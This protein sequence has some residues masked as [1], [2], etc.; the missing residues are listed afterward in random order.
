MEVPFG[1]CW[2][3]RAGAQ[4]KWNVSKMEGFYFRGSKEEYLCVFG[5]LPQTW[6]DRC[7]SSSHLMSG[8]APDT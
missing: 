8:T 1:R 7:G 6:S 5:E 4:V 2:G 3:P